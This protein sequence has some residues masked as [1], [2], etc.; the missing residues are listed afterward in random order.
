MKNLQYIFVLSS[1]INACAFADSSSTGYNEKATTPIDSA[2]QG[3]SLDIGGQYTWMS[4]TTPPTY[5]GSTGGAIGKLTFQEPKS[6]FGELRSVYNN[7]PLSSSMNSTR[8]SEWYSEFVGGYCFSLCPHWT[9]TPYA[10]MGFDFLTDHQSAYSSI[11]SIRLKYKLYY[12]VAGFDTHYTWNNWSFGAQVDC[13]PTFNQY[14][15]ITGLPGI[16]WKLQQRVGVAVRL[17]VGYKFT[18]NI[19]L[20]LAPYYRLLPI[21]ASSELDLP[22]RNLNQWGSFL[23]L[24]FFL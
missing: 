19:G 14:L 13:L 1:I 20:E 7:G 5:K 21:G 15:S 22:H 4:F 9:I 23:T 10:G 12:A 17:P 24:R 11:S 3:W 6:F 18:K 8:D 16:A 2:P